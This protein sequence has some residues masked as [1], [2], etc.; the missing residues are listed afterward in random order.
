[1]KKHTE[2]E[3]A[4][5]CKPYFDKGEEKMLCTEDGQVFYPNAE[6][7]A[8]FYAKTKKVLVKEISK[9]EPVKVKSAPAPKKK[10]EEKDI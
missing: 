5:I 8:Y 6:N 1:M 9:P 10:E 3:L 7:L 2:Q 4:V